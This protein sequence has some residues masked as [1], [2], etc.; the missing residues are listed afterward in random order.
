MD[1]RETLQAASAS[2]QAADRRISELEAENAELR[3][4]YALADGK[5]DAVKSRV[6]AFDASE[7]DDVAALTGIAEIVDLTYA[8]AQQISTARRKFVPKTLRE[9]LEHDAWG[10]DLP[11]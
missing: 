5:L 4:M 8:E 9:K 1:I 6:A 11:V 3:R 7:I 2:I 10:E